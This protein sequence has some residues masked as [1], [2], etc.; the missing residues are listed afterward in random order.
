MSCIIDTPFFKKYN[1]PF[2]YDNLT[3]GYLKKNIPLQ[4]SIFLSEKEIIIILV[5]ICLL[6]KE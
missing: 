6:I 4:N 5:F 1:F 3:I 2:D